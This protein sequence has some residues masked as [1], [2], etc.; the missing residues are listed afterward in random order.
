MNNNIIDGD[1]NFC[2]RNP[3]FRLCIT[4]IIIIVISVSIIYLIKYYI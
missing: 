4:Y 1:E 2:E 3:K